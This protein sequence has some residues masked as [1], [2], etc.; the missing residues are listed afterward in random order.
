MWIAAVCLAN[1]LPLAT[2]NIKDYEAF[3]EYHGLVL[4]TD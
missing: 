2:R 4:V 3:V 1:G